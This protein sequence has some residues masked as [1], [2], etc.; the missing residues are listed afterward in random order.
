MIN[1]DYVNGSICLETENI[2]RPYEAFMESCKTDINMMFADFDIMEEKIALESEI[3]G[4]APESIM[5]VYE[6]EKKNI[7]TKIG[8]MIITLCQK[9][10]EMIESVIEKFKSLAFGKKSDLQKLGIL[11]KKYPELQGEVIGAFKKGALELSDVKSLKEIDSAFDE[12]LKMAKKKD[13][14]PNTLRGKWEK[15][16]EKFEKD[17]K[18][19]GVV[20]V[21]A[22]TTSVITAIV[23]L[24]TL[25]SKIAESSDKLKESKK[26]RMEQKA[27]ALEA[28]EKAKADIAGPD[29]NTNTGAWRLLLDIQRYRDGKYAEL[30]KREGANMSTMF[31]WVASFLDKHASKLGEEKLYNIRKEAEKKSS[32]KK[33]S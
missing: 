17:E 20:K 31:N 16:K 11:L 4:S 8:E 29:V 7:F 32:D 3:M 22:A 1:I 25:P 28:I 21:A 10:V 19:W 13:V 2:F 5:M 26:K 12:V 30:I 9:F 18:S 14:D 27:A 23:A 6:S 24:K 15:A 33:D